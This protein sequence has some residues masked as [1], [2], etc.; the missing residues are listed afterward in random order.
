MTELAT[1][2]RTRTG[3]RKFSLG[4]GIQISRV[5]TSLIATLTKKHKIEPQDTLTAAKKKP[6]PTGMLELLT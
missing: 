5:L 4:P 1:R 6:N 3:P 2:G